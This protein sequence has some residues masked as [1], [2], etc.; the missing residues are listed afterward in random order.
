[1]APW[2][3]MRCRAELAA[4]ILWTSV[5]WCAQTWNTTKAQR[6]CLDSWSARVF[7]RIGRLR[8]HEQEDDGH[9]W[10]RRHREGHALV[11]KFGLPLSRLCLQSA[12][13]WAGHVARLTPQHWLAA[14]VRCRSLQWWGWRQKR[15]TCRQ[16]SVHP[17]R[18]EASRWESRFAARF[19]DGSAESPTENTGWL[20]HAQNRTLWREA[21]ASE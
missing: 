18:F 17:C 20:A 2:L 11:Q 21:V 19:G 13:R 4:K 14:I 6:T 16:T 10:R 5:L 3:A 12:F 8:R 1:M 15:H 9:W 7:A